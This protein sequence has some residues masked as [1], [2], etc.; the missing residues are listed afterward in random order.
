MVQNLQLSQAF[1]ELCLLTSQ[2]DEVQAEPDQDPPIGH[3]EIGTGCH[4]SS[5]PFFCR[6]G[7]LSGPAE[8][9]ISLFFM[10]VMRV[11]ES[12]SQPGLWLG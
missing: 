12:K 6:T 4:E 2:I 8:K 11:Q 7:R 5:L 3:E 9:G 10:F 1:F